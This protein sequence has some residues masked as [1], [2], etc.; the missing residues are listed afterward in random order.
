MAPVERIHKKKDRGYQDQDPRVRIRIKNQNQI[1]GGSSRRKWRS[2]R[3]RR[4]GGCKQRRLARVSGQSKFNLLRSVDAVQVARV[5]RTDGWFIVG[6]D[7]IR[8][9]YR[10][11]LE[12]DGGRRRTTKREW[13]KDG[14]WDIKDDGVEGKRVY[15]WKDGAIEGD[16]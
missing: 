2:R 6:A 9:R 16:G 10:P 11:A 15:R 5:A 14:C 7:G 12:D 4:S 1:L 8:L 13:D 3:R